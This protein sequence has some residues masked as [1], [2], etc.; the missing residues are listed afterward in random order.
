MSLW[1]RVPSSSYRIEPVHPCEPYTFE[2]QGELH[3]Y[4]LDWTPDGSQLIFA[5]GKTIQAIDAEGTRPQLIAD[6]N[7]VH[8]LRYYFH[9]D[10]SPVG[11]RIVYTTCR[12]PTDPPPR[13]W[14]SARDPD[15]GD[16]RSYDR[17]RR[18]YEIVTANIDGSNMQRLTEN[19]HVDHYPVWS[20]DGTRIAFIADPE[21]WLPDSGRLYTMAAD[22]TDVRLVAPSLDTVDFYPPVW[23]PDGQRIAFL[24]RDEKGPGVRRV[25]YTVA[26]DGSDLKRVS[27]IVGVPSWSPDS[28]ELAFAV[29]SSEAGVYAARPDGTGLRLITPGQAM[30][31]VWSPNGTEILFL[32]VKVGRWYLK[33]GAVHVVDTEGRDLRTIK[34]PHSVNAVWSPDGSRIAMHVFDDH[35]PS[36]SGRIATVARD[37]TDLRILVTWEPSDEFHGRGELVAGNP[38]PQ[39]GSDE[40]A[41][42]SAGVVVPNP[43]S[44]P[45]LVRDCE[46]LLTLRDT[47]TVRVFLNWSADKPITEWE[48]I[49]VGGSPVRIRGVVLQEYGLSG[50]IPPELGQLTA[51]ERLNLRWNSLRGSIPL[52]LSGLTELR[53]L[54]LDGNSLSGEIPP[55]LSL[56]TNLEVLNLRSSLKVGIP[57]ELGRLANLKTL[58][59]G[60]NQQGAAEIP[61]ELGD[62]TNLERLYLEYSGLTGSIPP[63]LG[64][65]TNLKTLS[66]RVNQLTGSI[67][68]ELGNLTNLKILDLG[69]NQL[70][71]SIPAEMSRLESLF[72]LTLAQRYGYKFSG[73]VPAELPGIWA[74]ESRLERCESEGTTSP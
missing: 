18:S 1:G 41:P 19:I 17:T 68:Q 13:W 72:E 14:P 62:L 49:T 52:E 2:Y 70:T 16:H 45:A 20:P 69:G 59:I 48:G 56:L 23:S 39:S 53:V 63:E 43:G 5:H 36:S 66:L 22:G 8:D 57:P 10:V 61:P 71:G 33:A 3:K 6:V 55:E 54:R 11:S 64:R 27:E 31:V 42:C 46:A 9:A 50:S 65:L 40:T 7:A 58:S 24:V 28:S 73:C 35:D 67:P 44:N 60:S 74:Y 26:A 47:F 34:G 4:F 12:F 37:G 21:D 25:L 38:N 29:G 51:L 32:M 15:D 30:R